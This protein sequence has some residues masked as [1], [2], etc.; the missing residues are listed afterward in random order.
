MANCN[1]I[2]SCAH[3]QP[4][5]NS[6]EISNPVKRTTYTRKHFQWKC[7]TFDLSSSLKFR[8][9]FYSRS[10]SSDGNHERRPSISRHCCI[11]GL[12]NPETAASVNWVPFIDQVLL[13]TS[14]FLAYM[15]GVIPHDKVINSHSIKDI[16]N[17]SSTSNNS[18][19]TSKRKSSSKIVDSWSEVKA[20]LLDGMDVFVHDDNLYNNFIE[21]QT[22]S[23]TRPLSLLAISGGPRL[24]LLCIALQHLH[25]EVMNISPIHGDG[26]RDEWLAVTSQLVQESVQ[27][28]CAEWLAGELFMQNKKQNK[29]LNDRIFAS[30]VGRKDLILQKIKRLEKENLYA[31]LFFFLRFGFLSDKKYYSNN[32]LAIHQN[33]ILE[34]LLVTMTDGISN[35]YLELISVD[36]S[37]SSEIAA[38]GLS[39]CS[40]STRVLQKLRNEV[41]LNEWLLQNFESVAS[42]YED[43]FELCTLQRKL[44]EETSI[45]NAKKIKWWKDII[46]KETPL[47][48]PHYILITQSPVFVKRTRELRALKGWRYYYSLFLEL[49][50]IA[51]PLVQT[52]FV[53]VR[54]AVSFFFVCFIGRSLGLIY[55][56]IRQ[57]ISWR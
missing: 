10:I 47:S 3:L 39:L 54:N 11:G 48:T 9:V 37:L 52:I 8:E 40:L 14:I 26:S 28:I 2:P 17:H 36:G 31:D 19:R 38:Q 18:G 49:F 42:M 1:F 23:A 44:L 46:F 7:E 56:G 51:M 50:D 20:K 33:D 32:M 15:G 45:G 29:E 35:M 55:T 21:V 25:K 24:R 27:P 4:Q 43:R 57:S 53:K 6:L 12:I 41:A 16:D 30:L 13:T 5:K 22:S 34:D